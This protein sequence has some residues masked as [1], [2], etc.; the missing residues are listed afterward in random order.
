VNHLKGLRKEF[1]EE[2]LN[3]KILKSFNRT[4]QPKVMTISKSKDL[5]SITHAELFGK[6]REYKMGMTRV[7]KEEE[8]EY[9]LSTEFLNTI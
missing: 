5:T 9:R 7:V 1:E 2:D 3:V 8:E 6:L 4:W